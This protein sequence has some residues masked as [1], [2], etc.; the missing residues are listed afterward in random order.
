MAMKSKIT[1]AGLGVLTSTFFLGNAVAFAAE[2]FD[3]VY[4]G[5]MTSTSK[6]T[7][8]TSG[9]GGGIRCYDREKQLLTIKEGKFEFPFTPQT[10][11]TVKGTVTEDGT[12][13]GKVQATQGGVYIAAH[14]TGNRVAGEAGGPA[15][16]YK[17]DLKRN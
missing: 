12:V 15:C 3:G 1:Q 14:I 17:F 9:R 6:S 4:T 2:S 8:G 16:A 5:P 10:G 11:G 13:S 7:A